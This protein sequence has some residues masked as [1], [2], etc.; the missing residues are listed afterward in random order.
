MCIRSRMLAALAAV[1]IAGAGCDSSSLVSGPGSFVG[2]TGNGSGAVTL[3]VSASSAA[4][5]T[6]TPVSIAV[7]AT[8][9]SAPVANDTQVTFSTNFGSFTDSSS[10]STVQRTTNGLASANVT[11]RTAGIATVTVAVGGV[12]KAVTVTFTTPPG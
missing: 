9:N 3:L 5:S 6:S 8:Q 1:A 10:P 4:V 2:S 7:S 11:S 12:T